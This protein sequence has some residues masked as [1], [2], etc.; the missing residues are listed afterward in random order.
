MLSTPSVQPIPE[1]IDDLPNI[2]GWEREVS[3]ITR[4]TQPV[5]LRGIPLDDRV[6]PAFA[7]G[8]HMHQPLILD[9]E[10]LAVPEERQGENPRV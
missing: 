5:F 4:D 9:G 7:I 3:S 6:R 10:D 2:S 8:L 1:I